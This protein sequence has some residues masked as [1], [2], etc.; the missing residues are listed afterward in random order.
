M[1]KVNSNPIKPIRDFLER[2]TLVKS[3][4]FSYNHLELH[5]SQEGYCIHSSQ[6]YSHKNQRYQKS[7]KLDDMF[8]LYHSITNT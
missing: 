3:L 2:I 8:P 6:N 7:L 1:E 4:L 5:L